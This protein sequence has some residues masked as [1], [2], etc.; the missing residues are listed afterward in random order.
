MAPGAS[1]QNVAIQSSSVFQGLWGFPDAFK[2]H[3]IWLYFNMRKSYITNNFTSPKFSWELSIQRNT[4]AEFFTDTVLALCEKR[5]GSAFLCWND[6]PGT[7]NW[8]WLGPSSQGTTKQDICVMKPTSNANIVGK[9]VLASEKQ[10]CVTIAETEPH[11]FRWSHIS[12]FFS[13]SGI[14]EVNLN[15]I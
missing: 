12:G 11:D 8:Q 13:W 2:D 5:L 9:L 7:A 10:L 1:S 14:S 6:L 15:F 3:W 4:D